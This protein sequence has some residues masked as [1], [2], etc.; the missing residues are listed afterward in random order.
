MYWFLG[1][2]KIV[3]NGINNKR[4]K[5]PLVKPKGLLVLMSQIRSQISLLFLL[6]CGRSADKISDDTKRDR[7]DELSYCLLSYTFVSS[8]ANK[9]RKCLAN[10]NGNTLI[11]IAYGPSVFSWL[12]INVRSLQ[13]FIFCTS[14]PVCFSSDRCCHGMFVSVIMHMYSAGS[15]SFQSWFSS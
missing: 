10:Q 11:I 3:V 8:P 9:V 14:N 5:L 6:K 4:H 12:L 15:Y 1:Q 2:K 7:V 13:S